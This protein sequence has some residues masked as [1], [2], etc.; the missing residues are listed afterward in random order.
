MMA[1]ADFEH[2]DFSEES[3]TERKDHTGDLAEMLYLSE[4]EKDVQTYCDRDFEFKYTSHEKRTY[5]KQRY[6]LGI[7]AYFIAQ[8]FHG[9]YYTPEISAFMRIS[10]IM[11]AE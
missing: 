6:E 2:E 4:A 9:Y 5:Q 10:A 1:A 8:F 11:K 7:S 3:F